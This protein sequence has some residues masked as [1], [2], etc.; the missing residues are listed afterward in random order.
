MAIEF[1]G[2]HPV[3]RCYNCN[4][5]MRWKGVVRGASGE[6]FD[7]E[8]I[9]GEEETKF[10]H[11]MECPKCHIV[12]FVANRGPWKEWAR[13]QIEAVE[14]FRALDE[15]DEK[16]AT[17]TEAFMDQFFRWKTSAAQASLKKAIND[18]LFDTQNPTVKW[19][20]NKK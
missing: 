9:G 14:T 2:D 3:L 11:R 17:T 16:Y 7:G 20:R 15:E 1:D 18:S 13:R 8:F 4:M 19:F 6:G 5:K 10:V 12:S